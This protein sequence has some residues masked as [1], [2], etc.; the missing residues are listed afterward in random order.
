MEGRGDGKGVGAGG[1]GRPA[2]PPPLE[3]CPLLLAPA[4]KKT[5]AESGC[6]SSAPTATKFPFSGRRIAFFSK[7]KLILSKF[8]KQLGSTRN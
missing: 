7:V 2:V 8:P 1:L 3:E 5:P 4:A 6:S